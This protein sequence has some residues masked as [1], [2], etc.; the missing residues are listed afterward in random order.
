LGGEVSVEIRGG[1][2]VSR[3][4]GM[5]RHTPAIVAFLLMAAILLD[6]RWYSELPMVPAEI[7]PEIIA[8]SDRDD[9]RAVLDVPFE[10]LLVDKDGMYL[11]TGHEQPMIAG[12]IARRTPLNPAVGW[13][14]QGTLDP[15]LLNMAGVDVIILHKEWDDEAGALDS[16]LRERLGTPLYEDERIA[17]FQSPD[18]AAAPTFITYSN[19]SPV[20]ER[21]ADI[22]FYAPS[23]GSATLTGMLVSRTPLEVTISLNN[24]PISTVTVDGETAL[25]VP[26]P[27][28]AGYNTV[29]LAL[30]PPCPANTG[31]A[32]TCA[33]VNVVEM[34]INQ[35]D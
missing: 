33:G 31:E 28:Q 13:L 15:A 24:Q 35:S 34:A 6:V 4:Q 21:S 3:K 14:L 7:P 20:L 5:A 19:L 10:H 9:I 16:F 26:F 2:D 22:Y 32:I 23:N 12:H 30:N 18:S 29:T 11:Q 1:E 17:A 8:L 27:Y 25:N